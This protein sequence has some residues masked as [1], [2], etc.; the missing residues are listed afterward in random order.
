MK[1]RINQSL[2]TMGLKSIFNIDEQLLKDIS[3]FEDNFKAL[4]HKDFFA[5]RPTEYTKNQVV[6]NS[7]T[8]GVSKEE[9]LKLK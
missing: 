7:N 5:K 2:E 8:V 1:A 9:I 3:W 4:S 6:Y